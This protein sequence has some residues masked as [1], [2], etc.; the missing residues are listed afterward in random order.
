M[1]T[2][3][4]TKEAMLD[5]MMELN[6]QNDYNKDSKKKAVA[7]FRNA[8]KVGNKVFLDIPL[9]LL[10]VDHEMYQR[11][12]QK[13][14]NKLARDWDDDK[15]EPIIVNYRNDGY[16][17]IIDGQHRFEARKMKSQMDENGI[18]DGSL[19]ACVFVGMT[20]QEEAKYF[21]GQNDGEKKLSHYDTYKSNV[22]WGEPID[23]AIK[24]VCDCYGI[25]VEKSATLHTLKSVTTARRIVKN[26]GKEALQWIFELM[27]KAGWN[28]YKDAY[29]D[30]MLSGFNDIYSMCENNLT[31]AQERLIE[32]CKITSPK[33]IT[34][35]SN[36]EYPTYG[37]KTRVT[38]L[39]DTVVKETNNKKVIKLKQAAM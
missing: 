39:L 34:S 16:F 30:I 37:Y 22:C 11:V 29:T 27:E 36:I 6:K 23:C 25:K 5:T 21:V 33:E 12:P 38:M 35:I 15:C 7:Y 3:T 26:N 18:Y 19:V 13:H 28:N 17:Y 24:D 10:K 32:F 8:T 31:L 9:E 20:V 1:T 2:T 14:L 4:R